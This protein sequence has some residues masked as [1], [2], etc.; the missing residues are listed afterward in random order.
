[1]NTDLKH[2]LFA[3][4]LVA[5]LWTS[6]S[7]A[8]D[9]KPKQAVCTAQIGVEIEGGIRLTRETHYEIEPEREQEFEALNCDGR[10][11][12]HAFSSPGTHLT[13]WAKGDADSAQSLRLMPEYFRTP[14]MTY[15]NLTIPNTADGY[16]AKIWLD[17]LE[18]RALCFLLL[19]TIDH[20][21]N[22]SLKG[23]IDEYFWVIELNPLRQLFYHKTMAAGYRRTPEKTRLNYI[24]NEEVQVAGDTLFIIS[25]LYNKITEVYIVEEDTISLLEERNAPHPSPAWKEM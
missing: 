14:G 9:R 4:A 24:C 23:S 5:Q 3:A 7:Q 1:M 11:C 16:D 10:R 25:S 18:G 6:C 13:I 17:T 22:D 15:H 12:N 19:N 8:G 21:R 2:Y 20:G